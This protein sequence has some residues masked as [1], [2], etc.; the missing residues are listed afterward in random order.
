MSNQKSINVSRTMNEVVI[1]FSEPTSVVA[2]NPQECVELMQ[3]LSDQMN[4]LSLSGSPII[5]RLS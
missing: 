1:E 3:A 5:T 4:Y 2:L